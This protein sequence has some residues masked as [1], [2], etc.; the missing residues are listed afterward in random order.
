MGKVTKEILSNDTG[1]EIKKAIDNLR[2]TV[3]AANSAKY[4]KTATLLEVTDARGNFTS[5]GQRLNKQA[6]DLNNT[7]R[8]PEIDEI[9]DDIKTFKNLILNLVHRDCSSVIAGVTE[10]SAQNPVKG[11]LQGLT[12]TP[13]SIIYSINPGGE[14]QNISD[15]S[16]LVEVSKSTNEIIRESFLEIYHANSLAYNE[17]LKEIYV[18][19][20]SKTNQAGTA[21][22]RYQQ[23]LIV[24]YE[25]FTIKDSVTPPQEVLDTNDHV[26]SVSYDNKNKVLGIGGLYHFWILSDW[27]TVEKQ[28]DLDLTY[29]APMANKFNNNQTSQQMIQLINNRLYQCRY[30]KNGINVYDLDGN[31][32]QNYYSFETDIPITLGEFEN[33]CIEDDGTIYIATTQRS[34]SNNMNFNFYDNTIFKSNLIYNGYKELLNYNT[35]IKMPNRRIDYYVDPTTTNKL[36]IGTSAYPFKHIQQAC[37]SINLLDVQVTV[38]CKTE[39]NYGFILL[40]SKT[41]VYI[42]GDNKATF[43]GAIFNYQNIVVV[44][45]TFDLSNDIIVD[46]DGY[47]NIYN[48]YSNVE[49]SNCT[50]ISDTKI[51][52]AMTNFHSDIKLNYC[53]FNNFVNAL[54]NRNLTN[55]NIVGVTFTNCDYKYIFDGFNTINYKS[56]NFIEDTNPSGVFPTF[57]NKNQ[58]IK[59]TKTGNNIIFNDTSVISQLT[60]Q[61]LY[62]TINVFI[63]NTPH[64]LVI[65]FR[66]IHCFTNKQFLN[67]NYKYDVLF[68]VTPNSNGFSIDINILETNIS[69]GAITNIT[70]NVSDIRFYTLYVTNL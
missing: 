59:Y 22:E 58:N 52:S 36:Q 19:A 16:W 69:T 67:G 1:K 43:Y 51:D 56:D 40:N 62:M 5:L 54:N 48:N 8:K 17:E 63:N 9:T 14:Y 31:L 60:T 50:F 47:K 41:K 49:Y 18:A 20:V 55:T 42:T 57:I 53:T 33:I 27:E 11:Y 34:Y 7:Y 61:L 15:Y 23:I 44:Q 68:E 24:D 2:D 4:D 30:F 29:T 64:N 32:L 10:Q 38:R 37:N 25:T 3:V 12:T 35:D 6:E 21:Q 39:A 46:N 70:Q 28:I 26:M 65:P 45:A 13:T 66:Y